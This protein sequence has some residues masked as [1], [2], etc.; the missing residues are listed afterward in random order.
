MSISLVTLLR[1]SEI[2][3]G[4]Q[5]NIPFIFSVFGR[6]WIMGKQTMKFFEWSNLKLDGHRRLAYETRSLKMSLVLKLA[7]P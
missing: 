4:H 6:H 7:S 3:V 1:F 5:E 2:G